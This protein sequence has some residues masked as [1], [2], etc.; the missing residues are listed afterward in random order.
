MK[1]E[2]SL[3]CAVVAE[4]AFTH[5][6]SRLALAVFRANGALIAAG[7]ALTSPLGLTS[8]RWQVM[9]AIAQAGST[10]A[11]AVAI[12]R[13]MGLARQSV[14]RVLDDLARAGLVAFHPNPAHRRSHL[15]ALTEEGRAL[16]AVV[17]ARWLAA[18]DRLAAA[19]AD[20]DPERVTETLRR[21]TETLDAGAEDGPA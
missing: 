1:K 8:A 6:L 14:Q 17:S 20:T 18:A 15:A 21:L 3:P 12:A 10:G 7:D 9:G 11:T 13:S 5:P 19:L 2:V 4:A 16:F